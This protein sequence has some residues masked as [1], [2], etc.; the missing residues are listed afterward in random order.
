MKNYIS[1]TNGHSFDC[2]NMILTLWFSNWSTAASSTCTYSTQN[3]YR[4]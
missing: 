1:K 3:F 4:L 2:M